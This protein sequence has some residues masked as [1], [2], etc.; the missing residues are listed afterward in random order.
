MGIQAASIQT[1]SGAQ[2]AEELATSTRTADNNVVLPTLKRR[3][4]NFDRTL[5]DAL[6]TIVTSR[7]QRLQ[8]TTKAIKT[9]ANS[10]TAAEINNLTNVISS[11]AMSTGRQRPALDTTDH[12][13]GRRK[14]DTATSSNKTREALPEP[15][16]PIL[17]LDRKSHRPKLLPTG[18][19]IVAAKDI[20]LGNARKLEGMAEEGGAPVTP[21]A[22]PRGPRDLHRP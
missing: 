7:D 1:A 11:N 18:V 16:P 5:R 15:R 13:Q 20:W 17:R 19:T 6:K 14:V 9:A 2:R 12:P 21:P 10:M 22:P 8:P 3:A 4:T